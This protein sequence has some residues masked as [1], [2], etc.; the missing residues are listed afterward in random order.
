[1]KTKGL[2]LKILAFVMFLLIIA[3]AQEAPSLVGPYL[4]NPQADG[5]TIC[6]VSDR[7]INNIKIDLNMPAAQ[8]NLKM[9]SQQI[10][11]TSW[12]VWKVEL[13]DL[14]P[15]T[16]YQYRLHYQKND[17]SRTKQLF[18]FKTLDRKSSSAKFVI[19]NDLHENVETL[20]KLLGCFDLKN[21]DFS[22]LLGDC[23]ENP[24]N[25]NEA[26]YYLNQ[27]ITN[28]DAAEIPFL[29]IRGNHE[30]RG[31]FHDKL[32]YLFDV[33]N[34]QPSA[35]FVKQKFYFTL[36]NG[37]VQILAMDCGEDFRKRYNIM[38]EYRK[39]ELSWLQKVLATKSVK[40]SAWR[41]K[42]CHI[43]LYNNNIWN[44]EPSR[45]MWEE[46][47]SRAKIDL[48]LAA[49]DHTYKILE[50]GQNY[51]VQNKDRQWTMQPPYPVMIGGGPQITKATVMLL[52]ADEQTLKV[53]TLGAVKGKIKEKINIKRPS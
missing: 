34:L 12:Y 29:F 18:N 50:K 42:L 37:P 19:F 22:V 10:P 53:K 35:D 27:Y 24:Q 33:P 32:A 13:N 44:S 8:K 5:I 39:G 23:W 41:V 9:H 38:Q 4:Q 48:S 2:Y 3:Q 43:P 52:S 36:K 17:T 49:H 6:C 14:L 46:T 31:Q 11:E 7:S 26:I 30:C 47:L 16:H 40:Q 45:K 20:K 15:A 28:L 25:A 21:N 1:M 51:T